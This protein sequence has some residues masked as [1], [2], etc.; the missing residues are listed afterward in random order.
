M[1]NGLCA[2]DPISGAK[3]IICMLTCLL[4]YKL[5]PDIDL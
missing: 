5:S 1:M 4:A 2:A 3:Q